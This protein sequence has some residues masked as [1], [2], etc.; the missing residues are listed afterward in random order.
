[1]I[2]SAWVSVVLA[3][4]AFRVARLVGWDDL[5]PIQRLRDR[6]V[7]ADYSQTGSA[8]AGYTSET[9][10]YAWRFRRPTLAH[11]LGCAFC[12]GFWVSCA[13]YVAW[14]EE[15]A[16]TLYV[17]APFALSAAVGLLAKNLDP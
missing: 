1:V 2:P 17:V 9:P 12:Q 11:F 15:P 10:S 14:L 8:N 6:V 4:G 3:L 13:V 7:G 5:P 16:W